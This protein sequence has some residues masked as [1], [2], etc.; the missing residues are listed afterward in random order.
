MLQLLEKISNLGGSDD[1]DS[2]EEFEDEE[3]EEIQQNG[4]T[5]E[6]IVDDEQL[7]K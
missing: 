6:N 3:V 5:E 7:K 4:E 2:D 1:G